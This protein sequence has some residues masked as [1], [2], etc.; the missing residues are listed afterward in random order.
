[1]VSNVVQDNFIRLFELV[2]A[3]EGGYVDHPMDLGGVTNLGVT[4][5]TLAEH[6]RRSVSDQEMRDLTR[7]DVE[8]I[9][10]ERYW[11]AC[12]C[13]DLPSGIDYGVFDFAVNS[14]PH[15]AIRVLQETTGARVDG[16]MGPQTL[17]EVGSILPSVLLHDYA[18]ARIDYLKRL[19]SFVHFGNGWTKRVNAVCAEASA[20]INADDPEARDE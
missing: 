19:S 6:L 2:L 12:K 1:M 8:P 5:K 11:D 20:M 4:R 13:D 15:R 17:A 10:R 3:A 7:D 14:G 18:A 9:Y 16:R